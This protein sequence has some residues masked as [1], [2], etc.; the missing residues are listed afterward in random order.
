MIYLINSCHG[1]PANSFLW[2]DSVK[3]RRPN[4]NKSLNY[5]KREHKVIPKTLFDEITSSGSEID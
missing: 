2:N 1:I 5:K 3:T 4:Q